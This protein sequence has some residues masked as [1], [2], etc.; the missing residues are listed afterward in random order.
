MLEAKK[1]EEK[2][3][4][5]PEVKFSERIMDLMESTQRPRIEVINALK[6]WNWDPAQ[7][8]MTLIGEEI[9]KQEAATPTVYTY[10]V[11]KW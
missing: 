9:K 6:Q 1:E 2:R 4:Q 5:P 8:F 11:K 10:H 3:S 7:A